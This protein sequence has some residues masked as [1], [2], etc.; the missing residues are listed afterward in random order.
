M[1]SDYTPWSPR[2][3]N[4]YD[5]WALARTKDIHGTQAS[6]FCTGGNGRKRLFV[7]ESNAQ[8]AADKLNRKIV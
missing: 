6:Q 2:F 7:S 8:A 5:R 3:L 1:A 4:G